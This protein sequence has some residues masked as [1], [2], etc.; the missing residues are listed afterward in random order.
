MK[1]IDD[2][3]EVVRLAHYLV[4]ESDEW[5]HLSASH[6][7]V[8]LLNYLEKPWHYDEDYQLMTHKMFRCDDCQ[9]V[10]EVE[11]EEQGEKAEAGDKQRCADCDEERRA[12]AMA[13]AE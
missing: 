3:G 5:D 4:N 1:W 11:T 8:E 9:T 6:K 13:G 2:Y 7:L 12:E 10:C